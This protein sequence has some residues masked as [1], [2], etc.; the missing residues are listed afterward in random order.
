[1]AIH[2]NSK[3]GG[4]FLSNIVKGEII[5]LSVFFSISVWLINSTNPVWDMQLKLTIILLSLFSKK[6]DECV[7]LMCEFLNVKDFLYF[8]VSETPS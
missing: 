5:L 4:L 6:C 3:V 8:T 7:K 1:M 2:R